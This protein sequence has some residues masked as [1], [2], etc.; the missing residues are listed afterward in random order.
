[1]IMRKG[2]DAAATLLALVVLAGC[3]KLTQDNYNK[4]KV[5]MSYSEVTQL[6]GKPNQCNDTLAAKSC[7]WES[8]ESHVNVTFVGDNAVMFSGK[9]LSR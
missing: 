8:G 1:M 4:L 5:G 2:V 6:L 9:G 7:D 3:S